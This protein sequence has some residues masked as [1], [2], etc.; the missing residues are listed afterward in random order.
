MTNSWAV[1]CPCS[2]GCVFASLTV[3]P[4]LSSQV[5]LQEDS[6]L[7]QHDPDSA[8]VRPRHAGCAAA[9]LEAGQGAVH[10]AVGDEGVAGVFGQLHHLRLLPPQVHHQGNAGLQAATHMLNT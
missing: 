3:V 6:E 8:A 7:A 1:A 4:A 5:R 2:L 10:A 9:H